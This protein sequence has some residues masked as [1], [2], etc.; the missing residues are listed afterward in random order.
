MQSVNIDVQACSRAK[1]D[2]SIRPTSSA[3]AARFGDFGAISA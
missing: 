1:W 2:V 3:I